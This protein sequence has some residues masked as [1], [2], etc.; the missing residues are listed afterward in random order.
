ML[1]EFLTS[2]RPVIV[3][4]CRVLVASRSGPET[5]PD[6]VVHGIPT[7]ID[8]VIE[9]LTTEQT[10]EHEVDKCISVRNPRGEI[11]SEVG[12]TA[13]LHG[14]DLF[15]EG[16]TIEQ[17][18]RDYGDVCQA[19]M[20]LAIETGAPI[21]VDEFRIFNRCLDNATAGAVTEFVKHTPA[22]RTAALRP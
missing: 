5:S 1:H 6:E 21:S 17:V 12:T 9:T 4:R 2:N 22:S 3:D 11:A 20:K 8:Q 13:G 7:F 10:S 19:V 16:F 18:A 15:R 14:R